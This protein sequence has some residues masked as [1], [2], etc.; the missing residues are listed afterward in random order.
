IP[1]E[2]LVLHIQILLAHL[3]ALAKPRWSW[4]IENLD[5]T[6]GAASY[7]NPVQSRT[8]FRRAVAYGPHLPRRQGIS[9]DRFVAV[10]LRSRDELLDSFC[11]HR[12]AEMCVS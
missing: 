8:C 5:T 6:P 3:N 2:L 11:T 4:L 12:I 1:H 7:L 9:F 10:E